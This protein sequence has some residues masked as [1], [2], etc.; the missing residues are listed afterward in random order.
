VLYEQDTYDRRGEEVTLVRREKIS[1]PE[2]GV[3]IEK[4]RKGR[5]SI[6]V[7]KYIR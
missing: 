6:N 3:R 1:E 4:D 2:G 5:M 7:P